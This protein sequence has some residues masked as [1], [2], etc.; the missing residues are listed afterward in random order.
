MTVHLAIGDEARRLLVDSKFI[1]AW[2]RLF[3]GCDWSTPFQSTAFTLPWYEIYSSQYD[4]LIVYSNVG[5]ELEGLWLL[6]QNL[7]TG[8][9]GHAGLHHAEYQT[10]LCERCSASRFIPATLKAVRPHCST[11]LIRLLFLAP[12]TPLDWLE[13][14]NSPVRT[15]L[16]WHQRGIMRLGNE[17]DFQSQL[18]GRKNR[19]KLNRLKRLGDVRLDRL[20]TRSDLEEVI[21]T[22]AIHCDLRQGATHQSLPFRDDPHKRELHLRMMEAGLLHAVVLRAGK[23]IVS[24]H[25]GICTSE[26]LMLG[27]IAHSPL[28]GAA[29]PGRIML[30]MLAQRLCEEGVTMFD[31]TPGGAYKDNFANDY[32]QVA[33]LDIFFKTTPFV[34]QAVRKRLGLLRRYLDDRLEIETKKLISLAER[35]FKKLRN[36]SPQRILRGTLKRLRAGLYFRQ[37]FCIYQIALAGLRHPTN[38]VLNV[39]N[40]DDLL[41]YERTD[42]EGPTL[43]EFLDQSVRKLDQGQVLFSYAREGRL[44]HYSWLIPKTDRCGTNFGHELQFSEPTAVLWDDYTV[45]SARGQ[46]LHK[47]SLEQRLA[48]AATIKGIEKA[49]V[50]VLAD[51]GASRR[52]I[53]AAGFRH[54]GSAWI[55][56]RLGTVRYWSDPSLVEIKI[57]R[58][59]NGS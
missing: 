38:P 32:D 36:R 35:S 11:G 54:V 20:D 26:G 23:D 31:L 59:R 19:Q 52:N 46:G 37:E 18:D 13:A 27:V 42:P 22:I 49:S 7:I 34:R 40:L 45:P 33:V 57:H 1:A 47:R 2:E 55:E 50:G 44:L 15:D 30:M 24:A 5:G 6:A 28:H 29:S 3:I 53:E 41:C 48:F 39:N 58:D 17:C 21:D 56:R 9:I 14:G 12:N 8:E 10:W 4:P 51:N 43:F 16:R 25:L